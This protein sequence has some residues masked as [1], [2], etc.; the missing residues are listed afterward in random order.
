MKKDKISLY[1]LFDLFTNLVDSFEIDK[2]IS[3]IPQKNITIND[4]TISDFDKLHY[5]GA[6][7]LLRIDENVVNASQVSCNFIICCRL[8]KRSKVF[9]RYR[10]DAYNNNSIIFDL[11]NYIPSDDVTL[12]I[13]AKEFKDIALIY[14]RFMKFKSLNTRCNNISYF[15][16]LAYRSKAWLE[17]LIFFVCALETITSSNKRENGVTEKF[18]SRINNFIGYN[19]NDLKRIYNVRSEL[20][21]GRDKHESK[22]LNLELMIIAEEVLR[23]VLL[24]IL[25]DESNLAIFTNDEK[26]LN[27]FTKIDKTI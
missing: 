15:I 5:L 3:V 1:P 4:A 8:Y 10:L 12:E 17:S 13:T 27:L 24:K 2:G 14:K 18:S 9:I 25:N 11:Y 6:Y 7:H 16:G 22:K 20:V 26:R 21:H 23:K 19:E